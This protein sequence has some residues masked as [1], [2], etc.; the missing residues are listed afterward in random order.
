MR[1]P[2]RQLLLVCFAAAMTFAA[3][4]ASAERL[5]DSLSGIEDRWVTATYEANTRQKQRD[6]KQL[7]NDVRSL[8]Q[9]YP[10][11]PEAAAWH[12]V[13]ARS[14]SDIKGSMRLAREA[15]DALL[16][17]ESLDPL[18]LGGQ[19]YANLGA[20]YSSVSAGFGGFGSKTRGIGYFW[21]AL[22]VD[23]EGLDAN[24]LYA[25]AMINQK[26]LPA[27]RDAL[28]RA[29]QSPES[30]AHLTADHARK[31]AVSVLLSKVELEIAE[32]H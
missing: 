26:N 28:R 25:Q 12:G 31:E 7:L 15:R 1:N 10:E 24:L 18:T 13:V 20:L 29:R 16:I 22:T 3:S 14:Y 4:M 2:V 9:R 32:L 6:L 30:S 17:A 11:Q 23:P 8:H 19:V 5:S 27:A 21:K